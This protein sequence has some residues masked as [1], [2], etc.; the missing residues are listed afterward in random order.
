MD[1]YDNRFPDWNLVVDGPVN[2]ARY[3]EILETCSNLSSEIE[4][5]RSA[6]GCSTMGHKYTSLFLCARRLEQTLCKPPDWQKFTI[7]NGHHL[8]LTIRHR[9]IPCVVV[10]REEWLRFTTPPTKS[11]AGCWGLLFH[12]YSTNAPKHVTEDM[13]AHPLV[14]TALRNFLT[15]NHKV[16]N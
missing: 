13:E 9:A 8:V 12:H 10:S 15:C 6:C 1:G 4:D 5:L 2:T 11:F 7:K 3:S 14:C 16:P